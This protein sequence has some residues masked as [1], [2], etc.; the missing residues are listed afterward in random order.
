MKNIIVTTPKTQM[1]IAKQEA[2]NCI[3]NGGGYYF[4]TFRNRPKELVIGSKVFYVED[5]Y[6]RG[7]GVVSN[8]VNG[9]MTCDVSGKDWGEGFHAIMDAKSWAWIKPIPMK[10]FQGWRYFNGNY[11]KIGNWLDP[12][13]NTLIGTDN[14]CDWIP[15]QNRW[16]QWVWRRED[17]AEDK[18]WPGLKPPTKTVV[19]KVINNLWHWVEEVKES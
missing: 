14:P 2:E 8:I 15:Y 19:P 16:G 10:G 9:N 1:D 7:F 5:G 17:I 3:N 6:I 4:R 18:N 13:P 11:E 12:K